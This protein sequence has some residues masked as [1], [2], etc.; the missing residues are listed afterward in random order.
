MQEWL[1][2]TDKDNY[3]KIRWL[4]KYIADKEY[5]ESDL[6]GVVPRYKRH[7]VLPKTY[8]SS[9]ITRVESDTDTATDT[10]KRNIAIIRFA[11]CMGFRSGDIANL[12]RSEVEL[13]TGYIHIIQEK[14]GEL[15]S[16]QVSDAV[17]NTI[18]LHIENTVLFSMD[19][20]FVFIVC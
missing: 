9:E 2:Y 16:L 8:A 1:I 12:K 20:G 19:C 10:R 7:K 6:S 13:E 14:I 11:T 17:F 3:A 5:T 18:L 15:L 4:L